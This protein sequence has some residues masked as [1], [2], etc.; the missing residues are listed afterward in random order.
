[1]F[2]KLNRIRELAF[3]KKRD[4]IKLNPQ[5]TSRGCVVI[6]YITWPF[7]EGVDSP[8]MRGHTNAYEVT[9]MA[10]AF[11]DLGFRVEVCDWKDDRYLPPEDCKVAID[12]HH[13]LERFAKVLPKASKK[14]FHATGP[15][16]IDCNIAELSR[17]KALQCRKSVVLRHRR[18]VEFSRAAEVSDHITVLGNSYTI[19]TYRFLE[20]PITRIPISSA[21][22]FDWPRDR[23]ITMAKRKFLW[24]SSYGMVWKGLDL[25]LDAFAGMPELELSVCGR[26]EKEEDFY[27]LYKSELRGKQNITYLGWMDM[28]SEKFREIATTHGSNIHVASSEGGGGSV[29]H[30][31]HAGMLPICTRE[32]SVD[33]GDFGFLVPE[34]SVAEVQ[35]ICRRIASLDNSEFEARAVAAYRHVRAKHSRS[36]F[37]RNY[38]A[39][40]AN[41]VAGIS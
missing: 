11:L 3:P 24:L 5:H 14:I 28:G 2:E 36:E 12:I 40:A 20:K 32:T 21:Y 37:K 9:V 19:E 18:Q 13:N 25:A 17:M 22:E 30:C 39:F 7:V 29:I 6:S 31:M 8:K 35:K 27:R 41:L 16:W 26:P 15:H 34:V 33:L 1:M 23:D 10:K 4:V 38:D